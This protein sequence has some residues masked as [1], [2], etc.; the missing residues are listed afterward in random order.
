M[1]VANDI[2]D[3]EEGGGRDV[4]NDMSGDEKASF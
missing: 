1:D 3:N 2:S 4:A